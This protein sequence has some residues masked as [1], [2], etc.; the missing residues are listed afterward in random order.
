MKVGNSKKAELPGLLRSLCHKPKHHAEQSLQCPLW[1]EAGALLPSIP[2]LHLLLCFLSHMPAFYFQTTLPEN[3]S[4]Q[5][6]EKKK[7][8]REKKEHYFS[9]VV[10][11]Q[12]AGT[13]R[14]SICY[15]SSFLRLSFVKMLNANARI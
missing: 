3:K 8:E 13:G 15:C 2:L 11:L 6:K 14:A 7:R 12:G 9:L 10:A 1:K 4:Y 5:G